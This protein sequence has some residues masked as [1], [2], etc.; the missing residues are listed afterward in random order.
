[1]SLPYSSSGLFMPSEDSAASFGFYTNGGGCGGDDNALA[2]FNPNKAFV[3]LDDDGKVKSAGR[4][5]L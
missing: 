4:D 5:V 2:A 1:M 3:V